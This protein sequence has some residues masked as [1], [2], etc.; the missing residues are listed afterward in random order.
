MFTRVSALILAVPLLV[1]AAVVPRT[2]WGG[3]SVSQCNT[4]AMQCC[5]DVQK[6]DSPTVQSLAGLL[7]LGLGA[8]TPQVGLHCSPLSVIGAGGTSCAAQ[9][10]CCSDN[11]FNGLIALGCT[12]INVVL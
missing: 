7:G 6:S 10:V 5:N 2:G 11:S 12:P 8:L 9:P 4:G 3:N 1:S